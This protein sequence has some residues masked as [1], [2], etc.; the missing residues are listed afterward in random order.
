MALVKWVGALALVGAAAAPVGV[1]VPAQAASFDCTKASTPYEQAIC[2]RADLSA[3]DERLAKAFS[4]AIGGLTTSASETMRSEQRA[5]LSYAQRVC[6]DDAKPLTTGKYDDDGA[7]CLLQKLNTRVAVLEASRMIGGHRFWITS[8]Y[9]AEPDPDEADN[10][11]SFWKVSSRENSHPML[12]SDDALAAKFNAFAA[13]QFAPDS[14]ESEYDLDG[15]SSDSINEVAV[16]DVSTTRITLETTDYWYP[17]GAAH[18]GGGVSYVHYLIAEDRAL[19]ASDVFKGSDWQDKLAE[20]TIAQLETNV[21][22]WLQMPERKTITDIV[23]SPQR[24]SFAD[25]YGL[26]IQFQQYEVAPYAYGMPTV[27]ISWENLAAVTAEDV[28]ALK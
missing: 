7:F 6:T 11:D 16:S 8:T 20:L 3:A 12:D 18:G 15:A 9:S 23:S 21:G 5:W 24:W 10:P 26:T 1:I 27:T 13:A 22:E 4:T 14:E 2:E 17:H 28:D 19:T 25:P